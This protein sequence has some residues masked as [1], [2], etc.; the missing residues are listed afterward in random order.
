MEIK[1]VKHEY[2]NMLLPTAWQNVIF[3]NYGRI[4]TEII[5]S[6]LHMDAGSVKDEAKNLGLEGITYDVNWRRLGHITLI[7]DNWH[8][9]S[10]EQIAQLLEITIEE[11]QDMLIIDDFLLVKLGNEKPITNCY[12]TPLTEEQR[13]E[14]ARIKEQV[15]AQRET[16]GV[17]PFDFKFS[18][19]PLT[20]PEYKGERVLYSYCALFGDALLDGNFSGYTDDALEALSSRGVTGIWLQGFLAKLTQY[21]FADY[22]EEYKIRQKNLSLLCERCSKY[23]IK[24]YLYFNEPRALPIGKAGEYGGHVEESTDSEALC[25]SH[26]A[27]QDYLVTATQSLCEAV[28][29]LGGIITITMS[30]NLT[31]CASLGWCNCKHCK[32]KSAPYQ[33]ALV[34]NLIAE[35]VRRSKTNVRV[36]ANLLGWSSFMGWTDEM[37]FEGVDYLDELVEIMLVSE[38]NKKINKGGVDSEVIDYSMSNVGPSECSEKVLRYA[39]SKGKKI[40][41]KIQID[42]TWECSAVPALP[43]Y[44]LIKEHLDNL[45]KI[46]VNDYMLSWTLGGY[47][48][49][50]LLLSTAYYGEDGVNLNAFY[51]DVFGKEAEEVKEISQNLCEAFKEFP[52]SLSVLYYSPH[53][54]GCGEYWTLD[55]ITRE[56][57]MVGFAYDDI[58]KYAFPFGGDIYVSQMQK[59][60]DGFL[61][62]VNKLEKLEAKTASIEELK[63]FVKGA[64]LHYYSAVN[65]T[66]FT[67]EK[68][69]GFPNKSYAIELIQREADVVKQ[70]YRLQNKDAR[71]G[72]EASNHYYYNENTLLLKLVNLQ[73]ISAALNE[74]KEE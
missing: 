14:T 62:C 7:R 21:P 50:N 16:R 23:G 26:K 66:Q 8:F 64:Y 2:G 47:P 34:N 15:L 11:L 71:I 32:N 46:G 63:N 3:I 38:Y 55:E 48:S 51:Q 60:T 45:Q 33:A 58:A 29:S 43:V 35:G 36:I 18:K 10:M 73:N 49:D 37:I 74:Q 31:H 27:V 44:E 22:G 59:L 12:Y 25:L 20:F 72:F 17:A 70:T 57:T 9:L 42:T 40:W 56:S 41:A 53:T 1:A 69:K 54:M 4:K 30:E 5:A 67:L 65:H 61:K 52:F 24:V 28:P 6:I 13:Q 39:V 19:S 68:K